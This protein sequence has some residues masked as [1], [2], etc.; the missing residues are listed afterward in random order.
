[1][2]VQLIFDKNSYFSKG[3]IPEYHGSFWLF[4][5]AIE[6]SRIATD[7]PVDEAIHTSLLRV[8][9]MKNRFRGNTCAAEFTPA[10]KKR[11]IHIFQNIN[12]V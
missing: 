8:D 2:K 7:R 11:A 1:M 5:R 4:W 10:K 6:T 9:S 3:G 12:L